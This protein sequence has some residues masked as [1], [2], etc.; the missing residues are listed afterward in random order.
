[1]KQDLVLFFSRIPWNSSLWNK[2]QEKTWNADAPCTVESMSC[3]GFFWKIN[4]VGRGQST[5][6]LNKCYYWMTFVDVWKVALVATP[7][8]FNIAPNNRPSQKETH[9]PTIMFWGYVW[10]RGC[11]FMGRCSGFGTLGRRWFRIW[12]HCGRGGW[13]AWGVFLGPRCGG[14]TKSFWAEDQEATIF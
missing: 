5:I 8:N 9:L 13:G 3:L 6:Q 1:M 4:A 12:S 14:Q 7:W 2:L 11:I 10:L